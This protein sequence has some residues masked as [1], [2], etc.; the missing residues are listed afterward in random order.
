MTNLQ[1]EM[2][3]RILRLTLRE[4]SQLAD[5]SHECIRRW[6]KRRSNPRPQQLARLVEA[7]KRTA[8]KRLNE[9]FWIASC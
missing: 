5:V 8:K 4:A 1:L 6:E 2:Q 9:L 3:R 7:Y